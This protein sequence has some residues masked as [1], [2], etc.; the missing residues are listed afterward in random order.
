MEHFVVRNAALVSAPTDE[1]NDG[2]RPNIS[3]T[4]YTEP[5]HAKSNRT[6]CPAADAGKRCSARTHYERLCVLQLGHK[7][8]AIAK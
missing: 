1:K 4:F 7:S 6:H 8:R 2:V 5:H 3:L